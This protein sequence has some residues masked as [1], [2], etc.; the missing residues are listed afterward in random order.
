MLITTDDKIK[1]QHFN[2]G[3]VYVHFWE[4]NIVFFY[5]SKTVEEKVSLEPFVYTL[6][7]EMKGK[8]KSEI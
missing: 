7:Y 5:C 3:T 6:D 4:L 1:K 8:F 2:V